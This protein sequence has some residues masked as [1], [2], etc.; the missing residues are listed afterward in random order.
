[1]SRLASYIGGMYPLIGDPAYPELW[2]GCVGA[3]AP[4]LG[5]TGLTLRDWSGFQSHGTL[6]NMDVGSD[7]VSS[8]GRYA[9]D[10]DGSNDW[11]TSPSVGVNTT[12]RSASFWFRTTRSVVG[13]NYM[14]VLG[15]GAGSTG[16]AFYVY[17]GTDAAAGT[18]TLGVTQFGDSIG[19]GSLA[20]NTGLWT[21]GAVTNVGTTW[22]VFVNG[23]Q[24]GQKSMTT[25]PASGNTVSI[26]RWPF[27]TPVST[28]ANFDGQLDDIRIFNRVLSVNEIRILSSRRGIAYELA[29]RR[30]GKVTAGFRAYWAARKAQIIG[31]GL[32]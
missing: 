26:G 30:R 12:S 5:P 31:G 3:W 4:C 16:A 9:L 7:W 6:T 23:L 8:F 25:A 1:M 19:G 13:G 15:W 21:H 18:D 11:V 20:V 10:F 17:V 2:R 32:N 24:V 28:N 27:S 29:P 22:T 14:C